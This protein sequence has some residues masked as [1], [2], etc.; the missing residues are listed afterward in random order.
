M[1]LNDL[2]HR[3]QPQPWTEGDNIPW[4]EPRFSRAMLKEH[5]SQEHDAASR[6]A[7]IIDKHVHFIHTHILQRT[8]AHIL[9]LGCG[10]GLYLERLAR[11]GHSGLGI[12]FSPASIEYATHT[13]QSA[14]L[15]CAY[16][17]A[18]LRQADFGANH[19]LAMLLFGEFNVFRPADIRLILRKAHA[20][21]K[22]GGKLLLEPISQAAIQNQAA[23]PFTWYTSANG[24]FSPHP[25][26]ALTESAWN[27]EQKVCATRFIIVETESDEVQIYSASYQAYS[28]EDFRALLAECGFEQVTFY[29]A[30]IGEGAPQDLIAIT[31]IK[32]TS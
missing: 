22:P 24:L 8:P 4:N 7:A 25:H 14:G 29:P 26:L 3:T 30:L 27:E 23:G 21:L 11:L 5:L 31:A 28:E 12:D 19:D 16:Q 20:A 32:Q 13:A 17:L 9:D 6:R 1:K 15:P 18:D 2:I 10:P